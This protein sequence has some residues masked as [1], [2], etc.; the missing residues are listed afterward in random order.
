MPFFRVELERHVSRVVELRQATSFV[1]EAVDQWAAH[2]AAFAVSRDENDL[3]KCM[4]GW[5]DDDDSRQASNDEQVR[6]P[7]VKYCLPCH[8]PY[9]TPW[10]DAMP[11]PEVP[12]G[13]S[14][15]K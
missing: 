9:T 3:C 15:A 14:E 8:M 4:S 7:V 1:V 12:N 10:L 5:A 6:D 11:K 2:E 13:E